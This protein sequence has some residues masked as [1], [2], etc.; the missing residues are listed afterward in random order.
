MALWKGTPCQRNQPYHQQQGN[1][2]GRPMRKLDQGLDLSLTQ[3]Y[4][5]ITQGPMA[6]TAGTRPGGAHKRTPQNHQHIKCHH[7]PGIGGKMTFLHSLSSQLHGL[8]MLGSSPNTLCII[9][10]ET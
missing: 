8:T 2:T 6:A 9:A 10:Q 1:A 3:Q 4:F 7:T 5:A